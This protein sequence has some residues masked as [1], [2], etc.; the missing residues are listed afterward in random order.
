MLGKQGAH[1]AEIL[2]GHVQ[3]MKSRLTPQGTRQMGGNICEGFKEKHLEE[4]I[5][6]VLHS[7]LELI[8]LCPPMSCTGWAQLSVEP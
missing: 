4:I 7:H 1:Q 6:G 3:T 8:W 5:Q 2:K